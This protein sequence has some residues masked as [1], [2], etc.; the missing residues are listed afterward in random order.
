MPLGQIIDIKY[1][2]QLAVK[3]IV[4]IPYCINSDIDIVENFVPAYLLRFT[5]NIWQLLD[6]EDIL[7]SEHNWEDGDNSILDLFGTYMQHQEEQ[8]VQYFGG[9]P[10]AAFEQGRPPF[11]EGSPRRSPRKNPNKEARLVPQ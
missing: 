3:A 9:T 7:L 10:V 2:K 8:F 11:K 5:R 4:P 6:E 1:L